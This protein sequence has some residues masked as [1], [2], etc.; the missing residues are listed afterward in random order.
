MDNQSHK[1]AQFYMIEHDLITDLI[2]LTDPRYLTWKQA[3]NHK[4]TQNLT[5]PK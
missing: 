2:K 5:H 4:A 1:Y 3:L